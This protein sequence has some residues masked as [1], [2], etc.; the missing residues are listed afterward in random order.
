[1]LLLSTYQKALLTLKYIYAPLY[2]DMSEV[3]DYDTYFET[4]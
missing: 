3:V 4:D 1:M 2:F